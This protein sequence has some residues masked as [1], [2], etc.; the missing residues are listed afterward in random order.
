MK[1]AVSD[2]PDAMEIHIPEKQKISNALPNINSLQK[3]L[4]ETQ[5]ELLPSQPKLSYPMITRY[6]RKLLNGENPP[7]IKIEG[8]AIVDGHHRYI[9]CCFVG[10]EVERHPYC[11]PKANEI[12]NWDLVVVDE[13]DYCK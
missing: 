7:P 3:F 6:V 5:F 10:V 4:R 12:T 2:M 8:Q 9:S 13:E 11:R 1:Y